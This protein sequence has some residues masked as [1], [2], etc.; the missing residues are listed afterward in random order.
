MIQAFRDEIF[1]YVNSP[2]FSIIG[3]LERRWKRRRNISTV[4]ITKIIEIFT[5]S[6]CFFFVTSC[7]ILEVN[8]RKQKPD[9]IVVVVVL[10][11]KASFNHIVY[12]YIFE[13]SNLYFIRRIRVTST[14]TKTGLSC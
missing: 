1:K 6:H 3:I 7:F 4:S 2:G 14:T 10:F 8:G 9:A 11:S 5:F 12:K 13:K